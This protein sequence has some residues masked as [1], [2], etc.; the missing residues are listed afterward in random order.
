MVIDLSM[1]MTQDSKEIDPRAIFNSLL[2]KSKK[3]NGYLRDVQSE[4]LD[5]WF[6]QRNNKDNVIKMNTGSGKTVVALLILQSCMNEMNEK[7]VY[8]VPDKYLVEQVETEA[9]DLGINVTTDP[10]DLKFMQKKAIL[11][12]TMHKL[13]NGKSIFGLRYENNID[14]GTFLIDDVHR[15]ME[16]AEDQSTLIIN[17]SD[18]KKLYSDIV[19][20]FADELARQ[21]KMNFNKIVGNDFLA[22]PMLIPFW[23]WQD[24]KEAV[25]NLISKY[26]DCYAFA[27]PLIE[28]IFELCHCT[29][30]NDRIEIS[31]KCIPIHKIK[32]FATAKRRIY[33]SA[34]LSDDSVL[35]SNFD[36][37]KDILKKSIVPKKASDIGDRM[38]LYPQALNPEISDESLKNKLKELSE[39][40]RVIVIVPSNIRANFW[41]DVAD[42]IYTGESLNMIRD[43]TR[44]L[45]VVVNRYE[46]IDLPD[47]SCRILVIDG[48]PT[49]RKQYDIIKESC[50]NL[51]EK[52]IKNRIQKIEQGMGR[53]VRSN[54]DYCS[55]VLMRKD[56]I[57]IIYNSNGDKYFSP[58]TQKQFELSLAMYDQLYNQSLDDIIETLDLC[59]EQNERWV[60]IGK[61][62]LNKVDY[63]SKLSFSNDAIVERKAFNCALK[64]NYE[65]ASSS[66]NTLLQNDDKDTC[67]WIMQ[68]KAEYLYLQDPASAH[69]LMQSAHEKNTSLLIPM[70]GIRNIRNIKMID[71]IE[72][73]LEY[74]NIKSKDSNGYII[75]VESVLDDLKFIAND[76][77][78]NAPKRFEKAIHELGKILG[79]DSCRPEKEYGDGGPDNLWFVDNNMAFVIE[80]KSGA[81]S[82]EISKDDCAQLLS[83]SQWFTN[84]YCSTDRSIDY[85]PILIH[86]SYTF[87][88]D[89]S[90]SGNMVIIGEKEMNNI[91]DAIK[92]FTKSLTSI[93]NATNNTDE[94]QKLLQMY[95]LTPKLFLDKFTHKYK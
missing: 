54:E 37:E 6:D 53:G 28:N 64:H 85:V 21:N 7:S 55:I 29:I 24:K 32:K 47:D 40:Y 50:L 60:S 48:L 70:D 52:T 14:V 65:E 11:I 9:K 43:K 73:I 17:R 20:L 30:S 94:I 82:K 69:K 33:M 18:N 22:M 45:D 1:L 15:C 3:Y 84:K 74:K 39:K 79:F 27:L 77:D 41:N 57:N 71:R 26:R 49:G 58:A 56:L 16:I 5:K 38:I 81:I 42:H 66:F 89:A 93:S 13:I 23:K 31:P 61:S 67:G 4:V 75:Y 25:V 8:I 80:C 92:K 83:S 59:L 44:G 34:T 68:E 62:H 88:N 36:V 95:Y 91:R 78:Y 2:N 35:I 19:L 72:N 46:G 63:D 12:I 86:K 90:P 87:A 10:N 76:V 51:N